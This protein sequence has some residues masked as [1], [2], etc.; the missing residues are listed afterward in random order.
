MENFTEKH[1]EIFI[2]KLQEIVA[3]KNNAKIIYGSN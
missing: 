1:A 2:K 3:R